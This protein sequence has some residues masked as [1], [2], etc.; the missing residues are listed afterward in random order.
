MLVSPGGYAVPTPATSPEFYRKL[1][2]VHAGKKMADYEVDFMIDN[3]LNQRVFREDVGAAERW[4][5]GMHLAARERGM[6][7]QCCMA[8]PSDLLASVLFPY[9]T[10][11]RASDDYAGSSVTNFNLQTSSLLG[12]ALGLKP[13][14]D[15]FFTTDNSPANPYM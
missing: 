5:A 8:L 9:V 14:K 12:F 6:S 10:N 15:V 1:F 13:S 3:F 7:I 4:L 11:Y 2:T